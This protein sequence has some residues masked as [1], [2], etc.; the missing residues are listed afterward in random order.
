MESKPQVRPWLLVTTIA[1]VAGGL[2]LSYVE[3][4][5][6]VATAHV[7]MHQEMSLPETRVDTGARSADGAVTTTQVSV[8]ATS[9][10]GYLQKEYGEGIVKPYIQL[11]MLDKLT[12]MLKEQYGDGWE[13]K[14]REILALAFPDMV[15]ELLRRYEQS[16]LFAEWH[17]AN[18]QAPYRDSS[19]RRRAEWDKRLEVFGEDAKKIWEDDYNRYQM[20]AALASI[21]SSFE[22]LDTRV[23]QYVD[24]MKSVYGSNY[25]E[26]VDPVA[27]QSG[28]LELQSTQRDLA[29]MP[30]RDR[31]SALHAIRESIGMDKPAIERLA[32]LDAARDA[33]RARGENYMQARQAL[34]GQYAGDEL[35][36]RVQALREETF[37]PDEVEII[38]GEEDAGYFRFSQPRVYGGN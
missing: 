14:L 36:S 24:A 33:E 7:P 38:R 29:K 13:A 22:P 2:Y 31:A 17:L 28:F 3:L 32:Q 20:E 11:K 34:Q 35:Q 4:N 6:P 16:M 37:L 21:D 9:L 23:G 18:A 5:R 1:T 26:R 25:A 30:P 12:Q 8:K 19:S 15:D 27:R 10:A